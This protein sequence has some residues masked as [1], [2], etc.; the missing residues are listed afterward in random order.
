MRLE[1]QHRAALHGLPVAMN[2]AGA[3]LGGI[4]ADMRARQAQDFAQE[5]DQQQPRTDHLADFPSVYSK[6][7]GV[8]LLHGHHLSVYMTVMKTNNAAST[9]IVKDWASNHRRVDSATAGAGRGCAP[10]AGIA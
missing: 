6:R 4:T 1:R 7:K 2:G 9:R 5:V 10:A 3:A 8:E